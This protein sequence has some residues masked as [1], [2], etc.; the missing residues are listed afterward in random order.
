LRARG[1]CGGIDTEVIDAER[2]TRNVERNVGAAGPRHRDLTLAGL[3]GGRT[4]ITFEFAWH[5]TP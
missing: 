3:H 5:R 2:P 4:R 1:G